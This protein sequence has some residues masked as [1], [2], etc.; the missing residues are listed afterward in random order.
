MLSQTKK[1]FKDDIE[2]KYDKS[3]FTTKVVLSNTEIDDARPTFIKE[4]DL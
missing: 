4:F 3:L 2:I 1:Y